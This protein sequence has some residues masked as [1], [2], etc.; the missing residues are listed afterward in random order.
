MHRKYVQKQKEGANL[1]LPWYT[2]NH[3]GMSIIQ[4]AII[5]IAQGNEF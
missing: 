4:N 5:K 2:L 3:E 1:I